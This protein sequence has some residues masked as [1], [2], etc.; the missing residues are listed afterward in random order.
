MTSYEHRG[1]AGCILVGGD[2]GWSVVMVALHRT[3]VSGMGEAPG[4]HR[5]LELLVLMHLRG[6]KWL[7]CGPNWLREDMEWRSLLIVWHIVSSYKGQFLTITDAP[8]FFIG[9]CEKVKLVEDHFVLIL[10]GREED[11]EIK[12]RLSELTWISC[13]WLIA[14]MS[15]S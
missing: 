14:G 3:K 8:S 6:K 13:W 12:Y 11:L 5:A 9:D 4:W 7:L 1:R 10:V 2:Q 15:I